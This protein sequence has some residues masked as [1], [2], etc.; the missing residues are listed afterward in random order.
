MC[1][2][3]Y[4]CVLHECSL[5]VFLLLLVCVSPVSFVLFCFV[6]YYILLL[7]SQCLAF[8][9]NQKQNVELDWRGSEKELGGIEKQEI[10]IIY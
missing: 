7:L 4:T 3:S 5:S 8:C 6:L 9:S 2:S 10:I 1:I